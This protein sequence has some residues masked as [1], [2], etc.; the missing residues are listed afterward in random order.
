MDI[1][2]TFDENR[3]DESGVFGRWDWESVP[4]HLQELH[5]SACRYCLTSHHIGT[6]D[7]GKVNMAL[8]R[9]GHSFVKLRAW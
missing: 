7:T 2:E 9:S 6:F 5:K 1:D 8:S 3:F 4:T